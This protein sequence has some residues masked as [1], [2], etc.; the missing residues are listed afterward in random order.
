MAHYGGYRDEQGAEHDIEKEASTYLPDQETIKPATTTQ[1]YLSSTSP[2]SIEETMEDLNFQRS[3]LETFDAAAQKESI[4]SSNDEEGKYKT[5]GL[6][7]FIS[8]QF[9]IFRSRYYR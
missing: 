7:T 5:S 9:L 8:D 6:V 2:K 3:E 4:V 1:H